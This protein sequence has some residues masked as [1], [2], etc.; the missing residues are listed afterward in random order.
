M[1]VL[2]KESFKDRVLEVIILRLQVAN[3][4]RTALRDNIP[5]TGPQLQR[6]FMNLARYP[7][8]IRNFGRFLASF[9]ARKRAFDFLFEVADLLHFFFNTAA[10]LMIVILKVET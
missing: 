8:G 4:Q 2:Q 10:G 1:D 9:F 6:A 3:H 5:S 7:P